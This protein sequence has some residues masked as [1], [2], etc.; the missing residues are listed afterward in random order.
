M[1]AVALRRCALS[2]A[3]PAL[4]LGAG[5][6]PAFAGKY[7]DHDEDDTKVVR[8][9]VC[10]KVIGH[11][12]KDDEKYYHNDDKGDRN[13]KHEFVIKLKT[14]EETERVK[15]RVK[16][17]EKVCKW[18]ELEFDRPRIH[19]DEPK[20]PDGYKLKDIK[21]KGRDLVRSWDHEAKFENED[22]AKIKV[23]VVNKKE[24]EKDDHD[25]HDDKDDKDDKGGK[26]GKGGKD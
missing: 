5:A 22:G 15:L 17:G 16:K 8:V 6:S 18:V 20:I 7:N 1:V 25:D 10:K 3:L 12:E 24:K 11:N 19:V 9:E 2:L 26:G 23:V 21:F 14:D 13:K 4:V